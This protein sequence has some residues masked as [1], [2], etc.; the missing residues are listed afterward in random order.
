MIH[1]G[2]RHGFSAHKTEPKLRQ[3][4]P[5]RHQVEQQVTFAPE[6]STKVKTSSIKVKEVHQKSSSGPVMALPNELM[7][8]LRD[9]IL[10]LTQKFD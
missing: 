10:G 2:N 6:V 3:H 8:Q 7:I 9:S 4:R 5:V 1:S